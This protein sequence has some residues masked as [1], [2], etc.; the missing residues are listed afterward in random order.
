[1]QNA[2]FELPSHVITFEHFWEGWPNKV[3]R[4]PA[5][6]AWDKAIKAGAK[7]E[8][9]IAGRDQYKRNKPAW[10][11]WLHGATFLNQKRWLAEYGNGQEK[12]D[13]IEELMNGRG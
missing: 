2:L 7:P 11:G 9:I 12:A 6:K 1:M 13:R 5:E 8:D 3:D 10:Q 4:S